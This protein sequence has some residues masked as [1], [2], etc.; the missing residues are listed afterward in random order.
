MPIEDRTG[1]CATCQGRAYRHPSRSGNI[2]DRWLH[3]DTKDWINN[4]HEVDPIPS[5][6]PQEES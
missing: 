1:T 4:P 3:R 2:P 6:P 5:T